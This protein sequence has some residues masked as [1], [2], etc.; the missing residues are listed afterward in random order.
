M[1]FENLAYGIVFIALLIGSYT[2][3]KKREVADWLNYALIF[4][5]AGIRILFSVVYHDWSY[6][7][8]GLF[9]LIAMF[10]LALLMFYTGQW[11]GG[12]SKMIMG[13]G[14]LIGLEL[15]LD[16][17]LVHYLINIL[18]FGALFGLAFSVYL[19][20]R[21]R[22]N[23]A[24]EFTIKFSEKNKTKWFVWGGTLALLIASIFV[25]SFVRLPVV[26][27]AGLLLLSFYAFIYLK[28]VEKSSL[29]VL[30]KPSEL[31]EGDWVVEEIKVGKKKIC[32]PK[33][34]GLEENQI[35]ELVKLARRGKIKKILVK[36]GF[37]F[38]PGFLIAFVVSHFWGNVLFKFL[39]IVL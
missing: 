13:L 24:K 39:G 28:A 3:F 14:T 8:Y 26:I 25:P 30:K 18:I 7:L 16:T 1:L 31:V 19:A 17:F 9:G 12:D 33:D 11:G 32:G 38:V 20:I 2:D 21:N 23:F 5:G 15:S 36:D 27:L 35:A 10:L 22:K 37:P 4:A 34:L 6:I 29:L